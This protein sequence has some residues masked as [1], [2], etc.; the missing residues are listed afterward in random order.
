MNFLKRMTVLLVVTSVMFVGCSLLL[1]VLRLMD[2]GATVDF[3]ALVYHDYNLR[4]IFGGIAGVLLAVNY[5][6]FTVYSV[7]IRRDKIIAFDNP[8]GRVSVSLSAVE[9]MV[10]RLLSK[11]EDV[12][13]SRVAI[14]ATRKGLDVKV[15]LTILSDVNI[16]GLTSRVQDLVRKKIN[17]MIGLEEKINVAIFVGRILTPEPRGAGKTDL[18]AENEAIEQNVPFHGYRGIG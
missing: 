16:P 10:R 14:G 2:F 12:K 7:N 6:V 1:F 18:V 15:R 17:D 8:A 4:M 11:K 9:E 5:V 3:W 13:D